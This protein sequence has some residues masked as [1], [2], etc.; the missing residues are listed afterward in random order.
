M[1]RVPF[2]DGWT[3]GPKLGA[4]EQPTPDTAPRPVRLPHDAIRDLARSAASDQGVNS[5]YHP[6]GVFEYARSVDVPLEWR[7]KTVQLEFEGVYRDATVFVD[8]AVVAHET[9]GY[10]GFVVALDP[11]LRF[12]QTQRIT[13]EARAHRDSRWYSG[14]GIHRPVHLVIADP[15]HVP[16]GGTR[17][18]T[19]DIDA[20]RAVVEIAT[21]VAN[22]TRHTRTP[23]VAWEVVAPDGTVAA[24]A[25]APVTVL[26]GS[27]AV[28]RVRIAVPGAQLWHPDTPWLYEARTSL[29]EGDVHLD[30]DTV[31]FG[32]R[33]LQVDPARGLRINGLPVLMRG[34]CVHHDN[35]PL[36]AAT[37][38]AAEDRRVRLLKAAGFNALRSAHNPMSR[39]M[40]DACDRYGVLVMDELTDVWTRSK[41]AFDSAVT[42]PDTWRHDVAAL[43]A[44][45]VNHPSVVMYSIGN[46]ILELGT[47]HGATWSR[48]LAE[49]V[50]ALDPT[51]P[52]TNGINGIIAN[53]PR[54][55]EAMAELEAA[56]P[57][58]MM[59]NMGEQ[60]ARMN[61][62]A[63]V[64][65]SIEESAAVLD[66]VGFNYADS[67]YRQ[68]A[69]QYPHRVIVG[70]ETF[71]AHIDA[72]WALVEVLPHV[73]GDFTWT[74]WDYLGEAG[75]GRVDY[76]DV[77]GYAPT[78]TAGPFPYLTAECG[79]LDITG[80]RRTVSF[81]RE[82]VY[83]L[84]TDPYIAVH[85]PQHHGRPTATTPWSWDDTVA[86]WSWDAAPGAP[87]TVDVY[88][89]ADEVELLLDGVSI[90]VEPVGGEK[91]FRARFE[92]TW[93]PGELVAVARRAGAESGRHALRS[94]AGSLALVAR[95]ES[96]EAGPDGLVYVVARVEDATGIVPC[97]ADTRVRVEVTGPGELAGL[98]TGR[99]RTEETFSSDTVT[100]YDGRAL[101]I[102][103]PTGA[104]EITVTVSAE[105]F[106]PARAVVIAHR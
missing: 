30:A 94:S 86:S 16:L 15:V 55:S 74:G 24:R 103:R 77:D 51:R 102:V 69:E 49:E 75:I 57:N 14:A 73:I 63:L 35:G 81:Y 98:G 67:R 87:V 22:G 25:D 26:P 19:P 46:E 93:Q 37:P 44:K 104:G 80:H 62:S 21:T 27:Q 96:D 23:R 60:M 76:T 6:G 32:I 7:D 83:G 41:T 105:G 45:D 18:T 28:A 99:A 11:F 2:H 56:D 66:I 50:R 90:G 40:L 97:D 36:G 43:V 85:R 53:L 82:I 42:F 106:A 89:D 68:D 70:S 71:P 8:G 72:M 59:A 33:R 39:A 12:G 54:M 3:V 84:R 31:A 38:D 4:F 58:T 17:V 101:A 5:G 95:A 29:D 79:D 1:I 52:V 13:V 9:S 47:P 48:R 34:A 92:T 88:A 61:A 91:A 65:D 20:D 64:S 78:G 100:T 10:N